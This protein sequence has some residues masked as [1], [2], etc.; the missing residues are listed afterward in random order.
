MSSRRRGS[1]STDWISNEGIERHRTSWGVVLAEVVTDCAQPAVG[2][3]VV[4]VLAA[5]L[6]MRR[7]RSDAILVLAIMAGTL[8]VSTVAK[9]AIRGPGPRGRCG[10]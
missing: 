6:G 10:R 7:R 2:V 5:W 1:S 9:Y 3:G 8:I 4:F